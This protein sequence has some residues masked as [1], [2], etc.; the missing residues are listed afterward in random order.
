MC[1]QIPL[2]AKRIDQVSLALMYS[3]RHGINREVSLFEIMKN[4]GCMHSRK[5]NRN[6]GIALPEYNAL[7]INIPGNYLAALFAGKTRNQFIKAVSQCKIKIMR[8]MNVTQRISHR[9][10]D[11]VNRYMQFP[12]DPGNILNERVRV[13]TTEGTHIY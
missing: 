10:S 12:C 8:I 9:S 3:K 2:A 1:R 13:K 6:P 7:L 4:I 11:K 5:I